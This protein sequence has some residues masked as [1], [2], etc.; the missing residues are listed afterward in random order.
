MADP[1]YPTDQ[2][3]YGAPP[4]YFPEQAQQQYPQHA[5]PPAGFVNPPQQGYTHTTVITSEPMMATS[6]KF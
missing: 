5:P 4:P 2:K 1:G 3:G 6:R